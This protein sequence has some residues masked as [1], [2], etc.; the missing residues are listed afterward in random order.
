MIA[1]LDR[2]YITMRPT[3][4][5]TRLLAYFLFEGRPLT[6]RGRWINPLVFAAH[7]LWSWLPMTTKDV[8]PIFILGVGRS[9]TTILGTILGMHRD[10]GYLNE[11][12]ALWQAALGDDDVI[13]SYSDAP[14]RFRMKATDASSIKR[15]RLHRSYRAFQRLSGSRRV[16]DKYPELIFRT[17]FVDQVLPDAKKL[18]LVRNG[19]ET[20]QSIRNWSERKGTYHDGLHHDWWGLDDRKWTL[21]VEQLIEPDPFFAPALDIIPTLTDHLDRAAIEWIVTMRELA[22]LRAAKCPGLMVVHYSDLV[23]RPQLTLE[24]ISSYCGLRDDPK[25]F[26]YAKSVLKPAKPYAAPR[27]H[28]AIQPLFDETMLASGFGPGQ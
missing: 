10:V 23:A 17:A 28:P 14:G 16:A 27:L 19:A 21:M 11:P 7:R 24:V 2:T 12:K 13:G 22:S 4:I 20:I 9:G 8:R 25:M 18:V 15:L 5:W 6:T 26:A 1:Q 3:K